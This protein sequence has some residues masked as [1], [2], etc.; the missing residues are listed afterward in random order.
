MQQSSVA[1]HPHGVQPWGNYY[2]AGERDIRA[3]GVLATCLIPY[4]SSVTVLCCT[5]EI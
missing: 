1:T 4:D 2:L 3:P 5:F